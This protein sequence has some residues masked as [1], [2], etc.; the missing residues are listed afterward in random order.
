M[1]AIMESKILKA[2]RKAVTAAVVKAAGEVAEAFMQQKYELFD[3][4]I[5]EL[6]DKDSF[7][8]PIERVY[9]ER[10]LRNRLE[11]FSPLE[12]LFNGREHELHGE[13]RFNA[14]IEA[15]LKTVSEPVENAA[16]PVDKPADPKA[17]VGA[18]KAVKWGELTEEGRKRF[19]LD[20]A[21]K[22]ADNARD[23]FMEQFGKYTEDG[24]DDMTLNS[25]NDSFLDYLDEMDYKVPG[26]EIEEDCAFV[27]D[28]VQKRSLDE[29]AKDPEAKRRCCA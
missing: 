24:V 6:N 21:N 2:D 20:R 26:N 15:A 19:A 10:D 1:Q 18:I 28:H 25:V 27:L 4:K 8:F 12:D 29:A 3:D 16:E 5:K 23:F 14:G 7:R 17:L 11:D 13:D 22:F 9:A